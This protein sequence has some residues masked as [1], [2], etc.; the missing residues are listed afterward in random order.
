MRET[1]ATVSGGVAEQCL[2]FGFCCFR[3]SIRGVTRFGGGQV[4]RKWVVIVYL[5][6]INLMLSNHGMILDDGSY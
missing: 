1:L 4:V 3:L 6:A 2:L 5:K